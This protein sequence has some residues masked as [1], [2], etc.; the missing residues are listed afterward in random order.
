MTGI[1][2]DFTR[3]EILS[4]PNISVDMNGV[5]LNFHE[6][7][8]EEWQFHAKQSHPK[9]RVK[10]IASH[11]HLLND[12]RGS[13]LNLQVRG[14]VPRALGLYQYDWGA[15]FKHLDF[16]INNTDHYISFSNKALFTVPPLV[17]HEI[18]SKDFLPAL[19]QFSV[20]ELLQELSVR[21][22]KPRRYA[23]EKPNN[24]IDIN[25]VLQNLQHKFEQQERLTA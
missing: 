16:S 4:Y 11:R 19:S 1:Y 24:I 10:I 14:L 2:K 15:F 23:V 5:F 3:E 12:S 25:D 18:S 21:Y 13:I 20:D 9:G 22:P 17:V 6:L 7:A 8:K